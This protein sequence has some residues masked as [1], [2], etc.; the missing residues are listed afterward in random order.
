MTNAGSPT[1]ADTRRDFDLIVVGAGVAGLS[2]A[3]YWLTE[4]DRDARV[5]IVEEGAQIGG[6]AIQHTFD[7]DG[8]SLVSPGGA[9]ELT[10]PSAFAP[11]V[12]SALS[13]LGVEI[14]RFYS[15]TVSTHYT[16]QG[17]EGHGYA[18]AASVW[19]RS[20]L[21]AH[22]RSAVADFAD[23]P[24]APR[25]K[26][27]VAALVSEPTDWLHGRTDDE[28]L[29]EL[30][31]RSCD[32]VLRD[33][34][35]LDD[36]THRFLRYS[37]SAQSGMTFDQHPALDAALIGYLGL[38]GI[39]VRPAGDPWAGL[40]R[41]GTRFFPHMDPPIFR[42]PDGNATIARAIAHHLI[43][44]L[45]D[46]ATVDDRLTAV[47]S[48]DALDRP[49]NQVRIRLNS[50]ATVLRHD[51]ADS[52]LVTVDGSGG[53]TRTYRARAAIVAA[54]AR[55]ATRLVP[56]LGQDQQA[57]AACLGRYPIV[58]ASIAFRNWRAWQSLGISR[59]S[60]PGHP[61]WQIAGLEFPVTI[62]AVTPSPSP[63]DP[64]TATALGALTEAGTDPATGAAAGRRRLLT[65]TA[66]HEIS[67]ELRGLLAEAL[68][69]GGLVADRDIAA[70][71]VEM[72][73]QGYARY[74]TSRDRPGDGS[75]AT[76]AKSR[77]AAGVGRI[78]VAGVDVI[79]HPFLDGA[80][81][82]AHLAVTH[83]AN[84]GAGR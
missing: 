75:A 67:A 64:T 28:K 18:F 14:D 6:P 16:D 66:R 29:A 74:S 25:A 39:G 78:A 79:D 65:A 8:R 42:F 10:F 30:R 22:G 34:A 62:G 32:G 51:G 61:T 3:F 80:M 63:D 82:S 43:P 20:H 50:M 37:T 11:A 70:V 15:D 52:V 5:L 24:I 2:A 55:A 41:T 84:G 38:D 21:V 72:W 54:P 4:V 60:W 71:R 83:L 47:M 81:E 53:A 57:T 68:A 33:F 59:I 26:A 76:E 56:E 58:S 44:D 35:S 1:P 12:T 9:Q 27:E 45:F 31:G 13:T 46:A 23:A 48:V 19:G 49:D 77:L 36:D 40:T 69:P 73:P 7:V 17:A